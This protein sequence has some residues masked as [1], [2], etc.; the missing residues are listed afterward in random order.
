MTVKRSPSAIAR[1][2]SIG[3]E[4]HRRREMTLANPSSGLHDWHLIELALETA[5]AATQHYLV[6]AHRRRA[7]LTAERERPTERAGAESTPSTAP[8][9]S[10]ET[11]RCQRGFDY[12][13][14]TVRCREKKDIWTGLM[15]RLLDDFP[16]KHADIVQALRAKGRN[17]SY[18]SRNRTTLFKKRDTAWVMSHSTELNNGWYLDKNLEGG[19][20]LMLLRTVVDAIGLTWSD[21][22]TVRLNSQRPHLR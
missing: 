16:D 8:S 10:P 18:L 3:D 20:M 13:G 12:R 9:T 7:E 14:A 11:H 21:D 5:I 17:R 4:W 19:R 15:Q 1:D 6:V 22:V 2:V